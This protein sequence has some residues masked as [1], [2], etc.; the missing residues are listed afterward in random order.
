MAES[1]GRGLRA[2]LA[3]PAPI[4]GTWVHTRSPEMVETIGAAGF[5]VV[6]IDLEH[7]EFGIEAVPDLLRAAEVTG[8]RT[9]VR[10]PDADASLIGRVLDAGAE[11]VMVPNVTEPDAALLA[12]RA[13][14]YPPDGDR[15]ASPAVRAAR[16]TIDPFD[17]ARARASAV[18]VIVQVEGPEGIAVLDAVLDT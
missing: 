12:L 17:H 6:L 11:G 7:G 14:R 15:G 9:I 3:E 1:T 5:D 13:S 8:C 10:V 4:F 18:A 2:R 16:Y